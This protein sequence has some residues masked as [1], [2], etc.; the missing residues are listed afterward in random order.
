M[1]EKISGKTIFIKLG[2]S[3]ITDKNAPHTINY[4]TLKRVVKELKEV[5]DSE[6]ELNLLVGHGGGSF[7]HPIAKAFRTA[8]GL[9]HAASARGF[10][11]C[12]NSASTLNRIIVDLM[13]D[14]GLNAVSIQP[15]A[16]C[17]AVDGE[18][19][20]IFF[21][22]LASSIKNGFI[23]VVFGDCVFDDVRGCTVISTEQ[24]LRHLCNYIRPDR[25]LCFEQVGGVYTSDPMLD[26][27]AQFIP[28]ITVENL[29]QQELDSCLGESYSID[30]TGGMREK[31]HQLLEIAKMG[32]ECEILSGR[33]GYVKRALRGE[34]GLGTVIS[35]HQHHSD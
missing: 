35:R 9:I 19:A 34:R 11:L 33:E 21:E 28:E 15:S 3:L 14:Y 29:N 5:I 20:R 1:L 7:P 17:M 32:I 4:D 27:E 13:I 16:C 23:P 10:A 6:S 30:V 12:Q 18:I 26:T 22:P 2:G 31:V 8:E 25:V 24:I